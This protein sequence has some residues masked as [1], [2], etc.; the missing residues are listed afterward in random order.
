MQLKSTVIDFDLKL[1]QRSE[2]IKTEKH[3]CLN[4]FFILKLNFVIFSII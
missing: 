1:S 3:P 2:I 4:L